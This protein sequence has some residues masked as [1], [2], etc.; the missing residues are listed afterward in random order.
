MMLPTR[1]E[2][3]A[4]SRIVYDVLPPTPQFQWPLLSSYLGTEVWVKH[5][6]HTA[7]GAFKIRGGLVYFDH[8]VHS[9]QRPKGVIAATRGNHGQSVGFAARR[10]GLPA[11][12]LVPYGNSKEK[13]AAMRAQ[14]V[15][16]IEHGE[17]YQ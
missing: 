15:E 17:D 3:E 14:G 16:L 6:N 11:T 13:N 5:E 2:L 1:T 12:I 10:Y 4:A 8:L 7:I 9:G